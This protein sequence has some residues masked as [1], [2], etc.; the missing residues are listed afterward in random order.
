MTEE[1][2]KMI[3]RR[4][5]RS[6]RV[7]AKTKTTSKNE[8]EEDPSGVAITTATSTGI[9]ASLLENN[10]SKESMEET[11]EALSL[12]K[13]KKKK[14]N[15]SEESL[16]AQKSSGKKF[17]KKKKTESVA[18]SIKSSASKASALLSSSP[19][20]KKKKSSSSHKDSP[21]FTSKKGKR[22]SKTKYHELDE[23][24]NSE[25]EDKFTALT[26]A[27]ECGGGKTASFETAEPKDKKL[28]KA[29]SN[30][31][32]PISASKSQS[33]RDDSSLRDIKMATPVDSFS[34][35]GSTSSRFKLGPLPTFGSSSI[36][37]DEI[38]FW[39]KSSRRNSPGSPTPSLEEDDTILTNDEDFLKL[40][41]SISSKD[42]KNRKVIS[43]PPLSDDDDDS[44]E[45]SSS[46]E[47][48]S[49]DEPEW[50]KKKK[51]YGQ[52]VGEKVA[53]VPHSKEPES[54][55][56]VEEEKEREE[57]EQ[58]SPKQNLPVWAN[59]RKALKKTNS[60]RNSVPSSPIVK[61]KESKPEIQQKEK[62]QEPP[63]AGLPAW[64]QAR[65]PSLK[66]TG[67]NDN[68][69][70]AT[71]TENTSTDTDKNA[72]K[73]SDKGDTSTAGLPAWAKRVS[74]KETGV[75]TNFTAA[76][77]TDDKVSS[78]ISSNDTSTQKNFEEKSDASTAGL[79]AWAQARRTS[80]KKTGVKAD[81]TVP[82]KTAANDT[83][84]K[85]KTTGNQSQQKESEQETPQAGLPPWANAR[86]S[87]KK[88]GSI[89]IVSAPAP[90]EDA[91]SPTK[92]A[93]PEND[94]SDGRPPWAMARNSLKSSSSHRG[95]HSEENLEG[96]ETSEPKKASNQV[97]EKAKNFQS[98]DGV[99]S[100][101][102]KKS[103]DHVKDNVDDKLGLEETPQP[104]VEE[105][106]Q[107]KSV[108]ERLSLWGKPPRA[109]SDRN[110]APTVVS[111]A[112]SDVTTSR[113]A[114][115]GK[116]QSDRSISGSV[117]VTSLGSQDS[118]HRNRMAAYLENTRSFENKIDTNK[119]L[120]VPS[121]SAQ[122]KAKPS[123]TPRMSNRHSVP[124]RT[125]SGGLSV[126]ERMKAFGGSSRNIASRDGDASSIDTGGGISITDA[127]NDE[128]KSVPSVKDRMKV[129][130][131]TNTSVTSTDIPTKVAITKSADQDDGGSNA[132]RSVSPFQ[133]EENP[134]TNPDHVAS[135][136]TDA[137]DRNKAKTW[138]AKP[139][140]V[141]AFAAGRMTLKKVKKDVH[142]SEEKERKDAPKLTRMYSSEN[143]K[144]VTPP[145]EK[146]D[147]YNL[148]RSN[149]NP[150]ANLKKVSPPVEKKW[151]SP[152]TEA[153]EAGK[154]Y[155]SQHELLRRVNP[156]IDTEKESTGEPELDIGD[157]QSGNKALI[158]LISS[159]S[160]RHDQKSAQDRALTI[161]KGM[162][163][164]PDQME[165]V[166]GADPIKKER[167]DE[168]FDISGV[169][170]NYPQ[171]FLI[172]SNEKITYMTDWEGF[173][174]MHEMKILSESMNLASSSKYGGTESLQSSKDSFA[175]FASAEA[176]DTATPNQPNDDI[177]KGTTPGQGNASE[178]KASEDSDVSNV[179]NT[180]EKED[181]PVTDESMPRVEIG[182]IEGEKNESEASEKTSTDDKTEASEGDAQIDEAKVN[183]D[184]TAVAADD[185]GSVAESPKNNS[186]LPSN[187]V[188]ATANEEDPASS[189]DCVEA[190]VS[191]E[192]DYK[193]SIEAKN[194]NEASE[195]VGEVD[196][197]K[198]DA[199]DSSVDEDSPNA[200][201]EENEVPAEDGIVASPDDVAKVQDMPNGD[202]LLEL[203]ENST[204]NKDCVD[205]E[206]NATECEVSEEKDAVMTG[207][208]GD[209]EVEVSEQKYEPQVPSI[210][211][212]NGAGDTSEETKMEEFEDNAVN[213]IVEGVDNESTTNSNAAK[214]SNT[215][216]EEQEDV[217]KSDSVSTT[218]GRHSSEAEP[219]VE[220]NAGGESSDS[221]SE[222]SSSSKND[223]DNAESDDSV[224]V[225]NGDENETVELPEPAVK[226]PKDDD[227]EEIQD[228]DAGPGDTEVDA[229][230]PKAAISE[231]PI[232]EGDTSVEN[233]EENNQ[234]DADD[235]EVPVKFGG[236][237]EN[238]VEKSNAELLKILEETGYLSND[239]AKQSMAL[240]SFLKG[241]GDEKL[242]R[243]KTGS[244]HSDDSSK[245]NSG[246]KQLSMRSLSDH[247]SRDTSRDASK[248][249]SDFKSDTS[250]ADEESSGGWS[251]DDSATIKSEITDITYG[252][253]G[254]A[255]VVDA[256]AQTSTE[257]ASK[258][259]RRMLAA[260]AAQS[261]EDII[262]GL[263]PDLPPP[264]KA[265]SPAKTQKKTPP[266]KASSGGEILFTPP[267]PLEESD[268]SES[269][270]EGDNTKK[271]VKS[272]K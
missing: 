103:T 165:T 92:S 97:L 31:A 150:M 210:D 229:S 75:P 183:C 79:P 85:A 198:E 42:I 169:R 141:P 41:K 102:K 91:P 94:T 130:D 243:L 263:P 33:E 153:E 74:L 249:A 25:A 230:S 202:N 260:K 149:H 212:P 65:R 152:K 201:G 45:S 114:T 272:A 133:T 7:A 32:L 29:S 161:L 51:M 261:Q 156:P 39:K 216:T 116:S 158:M 128:E 37:D 140:P 6:M 237:T 247:L 44:D 23:E 112:E 54:S 135:S 129:W 195:F 239:S 270:H 188:V 76:A 120:I 106:G 187:E 81:T 185:D 96:A 108:K 205:D 252:T 24:D 47:P 18:E 22:K 162:E 271:S 265:S 208:N 236:E 8:D 241:A 167:R 174:S 43:P 117:S 87:L 121:E 138:A 86:K 100:W 215:T 251:D 179:V 228:E 159:V 168:L 225:P 19:K 178:S 48:S 240:S 131:Q 52:A 71:K 28:S 124:A 144:K 13:A 244:I 10:G 66:K 4:K 30:N 233:K 246:K 160:G 99:P 57:E 107:L 89:R 58:E 72:Q 253:L 172:D 109:Q 118:S 16:D 154:L 200:D 193:A 266:P 50:V 221:S 145:P 214:E 262:P 267:R 105:T 238:L 146:K 83:N 56:D 192:N 259:L 219:S 211:T 206:E 232:T 181:W 222:A 245:N 170:G 12:K 11:S 132:P 257:E 49:D 26:S 235:I 5:L 194:K 21:T 177:D 136:E 196:S 224:P 127:D 269:E 227:H 268:G 69:N 119:P 182:D 231:E 64:A 3:D 60:A 35:R 36:D 110:L 134:N 84:D 38:P 175:E 204:T 20:K 53:Y 137:Y 122:K 226:S 101:A 258:R 63:K 147:H 234:A 126:K 123:A 82:E 104:T 68:S 93:E 248:S 217:E 173:E 9:E 180:E 139:A 80:L 46:E 143:L 242:E 189:D 255:V 142:S 171:F 148:P 164:S 197:L 14:K 111:A 62:E 176:S 218:E 190:E 250:S 213:S 163:I 73:E 207:Q 115:M 256:T 254:S 59:A 184:E 40:N 61:E 203:D 95:L 2:S 17:K 209:S 98:P 88:S 155:S 15:S 186:E 113:R 78:K 151:Q 70:T 157:L 223:E 199:N 90:V 264:Q 125:A 27:F 1:T 191:S 55:P 67:I 220:E 77:K 34:K 166:D